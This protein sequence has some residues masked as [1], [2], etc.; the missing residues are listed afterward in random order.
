MRSYVAFLCLCLLSAERVCAF[1]M[2]QPVIGSSRK[3]G[4]A[5]GFCGKNNQFVLNMA[6]KDPSRSG[7]KTERMDRLAEMEKLGS[8]NEDNSVFVKAAGAFA[9]FIVLAIAAAAASGLLTQY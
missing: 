8:A 2:P 6:P 4:D 1:T 5:S 7:T 3:T 9:A